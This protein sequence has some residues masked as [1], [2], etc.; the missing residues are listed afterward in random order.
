M[1]AWGHGPFE[2][3]D[4]S[5]WIEEL[6]ESEDLSAIEAAFKPVV[7]AGSA[8]IE[9]PKCCAALAAAEVVA[10][11]SRRPGDALPDE[12][13]G[14]VEGRGAVPPALVL[15]AKRAVSAIKAKSEL[16][17]LWKETDYFHDWLE[18]VENLESRLT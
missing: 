6:G 5:D 16:R 15:S 11:L 8:E 18:T 4:A 17:E 7:A 3:D 14:W 13:V 1:G 9:A 12:V 10:A 2:N